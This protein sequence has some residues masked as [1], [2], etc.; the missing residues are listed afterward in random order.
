M[1]TSTS[2]PTDFRGVN[3]ACPSKDL[4]HLYVT[5]EDISSTTTLLLRAIESIL[6][7]VRYKALVMSIFG[8]TDVNYC[9]EVVAEGVEQS[10]AQGRLQPYVGSQ[11]GK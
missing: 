11:M 4:E 1:H 7:V 10:A 2:D 8:M 6:I 9:E 3:R 5:T